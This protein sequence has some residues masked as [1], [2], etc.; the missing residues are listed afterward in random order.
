MLVLFTLFAVVVGLFELISPWLRGDINHLSRNL[1]TYLQEF[2]DRIKEAATG[3]PAIER[4]LNDP[5]LANRFEPA[6][7][8]FLGRI[9]HYS[10]SLV[11]IL[12]AGLVCVTVTAYM[13]AMPSLSSGVSYRPS[14]GV[15]RLPLTLA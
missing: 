13:L 1:P 4:A 6:A 10:L 15:I 7:E 8:L 2:Q 5:N 9:G 12:V 14:L 11:T 3:Y